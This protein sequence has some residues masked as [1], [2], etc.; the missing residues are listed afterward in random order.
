MQTWKIGPVVALL[1]G[2]LGGTLTWVLLLV[3]SPSVGWLY[4]FASPLDVLLIP[5]LG[6]AACAGLVA[7]CLRAHMRADADLRLALGFALPGLA[8]L[9]YW[10]ALDTLLSF[11]GRNWVIICL[12]VLYP[13]VVSGVTLLVTRWRSARL[14]VAV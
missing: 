12:A 13:P 1:V 11:G 10:V 2:T 5:C 8:M 3:C 9:S 7:G 14:T 6:F 4:R